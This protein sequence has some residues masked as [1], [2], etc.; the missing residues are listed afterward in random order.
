VLRSGIAPAKLALGTGCAAVAD[1][2]VMTRASL[3]LGITRAM[4]LPPFYF[5][6]APDEGI[7]DAFA[8]VIEGVA[9][10]RLSAC[11]PHPRITRPLVEGCRTAGS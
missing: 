8:E 4:I 6:G 9:D 7:E 2:I 5:A 3:A 11:L 10:A 1:T